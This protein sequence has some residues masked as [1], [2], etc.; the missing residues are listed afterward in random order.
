MLIVFY[1][2]LDFRSPA[3]CVTLTVFGYTAVLPSVKSQ[4]CQSPSFL[5]STDHLDLLGL[6]VGSYVRFS[7][8]ELNW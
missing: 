5:S 7:G 3:F 1:L 4:L 8:I 6:N 2:H